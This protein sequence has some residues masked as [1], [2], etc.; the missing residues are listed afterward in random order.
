LA[1]FFEDLLPRLQELEY[2]GLCPKKLH[3]QAAASSSTPL[4]LPHLRTLTIRGFA[5]HP[6]P[7]TWFMGGR[8]LNLCAD[9]AM[10][11]RWL[12]PEGGGDADAACCP[13]ASVRVLDISARSRTVFT[14]PNVARLLRA[15]PQ[16]ETLIVLAS[17]VK[18]DASWLTH[19]ASVELVHRK[20]R[21][22]HFA[23]LT[24]PAL[25]SDCLARLRERHFPRL[26]FVAIDGRLYFA[27]PLT[28]RR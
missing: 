7:W 3:S 16:L 28:P 26:Q 1:G 4:P 11:E 24:L 22:I 23:G 9:D 25:S 19:P 27:P 20:L 12:P 21:R 14:A 17:G 15:A 5:S 6:P 10:I 2:T 8:P 13:L 18:A